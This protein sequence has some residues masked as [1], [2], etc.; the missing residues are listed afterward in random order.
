M[1][2]VKR[3]NPLAYLGIAFA[4]IVLIST[5]SYWLTGN[6]WLSSLFTRRTIL[7]PAQLSFY[8]YDFF[9]NNELVYLSHSIF[10][11]FLEYPYELNPAHLIA[12]TYFN[13]PEMGANNGITADAYMNF[14]LAGL[15]IWAVLLASILKLL[16][17]CSKRVEFKIGVAAIV[18]PAIVLTNSALL[19]SLLTHGILLA[20]LIIYLLPRE[21]VKN[22]T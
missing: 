14:G 18:M 7:L 16:D 13:L 20:L 2:I 3:H 11:G 6:L 17:A 1:W 10:R 9:S 21:A 19:T 4:G 5:L 8:Y 12:Q 22:G 15:A